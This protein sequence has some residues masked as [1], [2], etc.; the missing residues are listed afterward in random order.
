MWIH[1]EVKFHGE[2][3]KQKP[4]RRFLNYREPSLKTSLKLVPIIFTAIEGDF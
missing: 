3:L 4:D 1:G 2:A